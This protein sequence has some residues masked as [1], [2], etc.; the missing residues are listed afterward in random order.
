[1]VRIRVGCSEYCATPYRA[2]HTIA[3]N[4]KLQS[5]EERVKPHGHHKER[6]SNTWKRM[7]GVP[8]TD[9]LLGRLSIQNSR[10]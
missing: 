7:R 3:N 4:N 8:T 5:T 1:M 2:H 10:H 9:V 6:L